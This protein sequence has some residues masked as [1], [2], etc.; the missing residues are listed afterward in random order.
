MLE[1]KKKKREIIRQTMIEIKN[2]HVFMTLFI[3]FFTMTTKNHETE[4]KS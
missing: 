1:L 4:L 3:N 2:N